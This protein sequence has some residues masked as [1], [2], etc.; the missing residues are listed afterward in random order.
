[1][2]GCDTGFGNM[3]A[4]RL[5][6]LGCHVF[7]GC[8][9]TGGGEELKKESSDKLTV[10]PLDVGNAESVKKAFSIVKAALPEGKGRTVSFKLR[11]F[12]LL[13][14]YSQFFISFTVLLELQLLNLY[15]RFYYL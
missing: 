5:D 4:K 2:T 6:K 15:L 14:S 12:Q 3:I 9:T 8:L 11:L 7:A 13:L 10:V 1:M